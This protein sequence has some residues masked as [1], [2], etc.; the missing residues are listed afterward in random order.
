MFRAYFM[1]FV[2]NMFR[3]VRRFFPLSYNRA[4]SGR[5][6]KAW[7]RCD[8]RRHQRKN[9]KIHSKM[10]ETLAISETVETPVR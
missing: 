1:Q 4:I 6:R 8:E 2:L 3:R 9:D 7:A 5:S 10:V